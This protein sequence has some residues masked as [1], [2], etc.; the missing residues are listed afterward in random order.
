MTILWNFTKE[1]LDQFAGYFEAK[2]VDTNPFDMEEDVKKLMKTLKDM[3][4]DKKCNA[5]L[6]ILE[7]I[8]KW[9]VFLPLISELRDEAMRPRHWNAIKAKV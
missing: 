5:Y 4:C 9:L 6:G 8:K 7:D 3:K 2:W 1:C